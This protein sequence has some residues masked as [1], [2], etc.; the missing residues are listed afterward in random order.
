MRA[1]TARP[2][3]YPVMMQHWRRLAFLHWRYPPD[4]VQALLP[5]GLR[6][7]TF[8]GDAWVGLI[9]FLMAGVR[10]PRVPAL[11]WLSRFAE[12]N[13]RTYVT[14]PDGRSGIWFFSLDAARAPAVLAGRVGY[15][16]PY[17]WSA[18][19]VRVAGRV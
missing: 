10:L 1:P 4:V 16:L 9:P 15:G 12:T 3:R 7:E 18:M 6:V 5:E 8:D 17:E 13:V 14:G 2:V 11:P 19:T